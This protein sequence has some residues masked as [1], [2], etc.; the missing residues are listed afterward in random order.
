MPNEN[1]DI[2]VGNTE[3]TISQDLKIL[4]IKNMNKLII[5]HLNINSLR[6][7]FVFLKE[8]INNNVDILVITETKLDESFPKGQF[9]LDG[10]STP[11]RLDRN[12]HGGGIL[13]FIREDIPSKLLLV[14]NN[15]VEGFYVEINLHKNKWLISCS[16]NPK[17]NT[18]G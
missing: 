15:P 9:V 1:P 2:L 18:I 7:K 8:A 11:Y 17:I 4:R 12:C 5:A 6:N 13:M 14:E 10:F 16:Y 3:N